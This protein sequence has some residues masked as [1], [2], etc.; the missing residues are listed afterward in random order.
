MQKFPLQLVANQP[1]T[2]L[3]S[4]MDLADYCCG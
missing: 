4:Q 1:T 3:H 2:R